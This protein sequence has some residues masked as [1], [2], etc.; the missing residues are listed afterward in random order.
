MK[1]FR[2]LASL[3][4]LILLLATRSVVA[5][6]IEYVTVQAQGQG[7]TQAHATGM[8]LSAAVA[9]VNGAQVAAS[10]ASAELTAALDTP[11]GSSFTSASASA[12]AIS[13]TTRGLVR[14]Y[15]VLSKSQVDGLWQVEVRASIPRYARSPQADRLRMSVLPFRIDNRSQAVARDRF[16]DALNSH[17]TQ[18]RR[19]AMLDRQYEYER[20]LE[21]GI[22]ASDDAPIEE[23]AR[24]GN[25][26]GTDYM[27]VGTLEKA[28]TTTRSTQLAGRTLSV[29]TAH[30]SLNYRIVDAA[31]GQVKFADS[32]S[33][34]KESGSVEALASQ[35][36]EAISRD[37][38]DAIAP[39][40]VERVSGDTLFL[41]QGG[42]AVKVGQ[43]YRLIQYGEQITDSYSG[44]S[45]GREENPVGLIEITEVQSKLAK[46]RVL[47]SSIDLAQDFAPARFVVRLDSQPK[48]TPRTAAPVQAPQKP[49]QRAPTIKQKVEEDW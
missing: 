16:V 33:A 44:E 13:Q 11:E 31:T 9:Q 24:L 46:A 17:L 19:F 18:T 34:S 32:W 23:M 26:L 38:V 12:E 43:R 37:I 29:S 4:G 3:A 42:K 41:G 36:A 5:A 10:L 20:Q 28:H 2:M 48:P 22:A 40:L 7:Q 27:V 6:G 14:E 49:A 39:I 25:R 30:F 15:Q 1:S 8:A 45:L 21:M 35:A 47:E